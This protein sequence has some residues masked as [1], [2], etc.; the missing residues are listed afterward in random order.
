M[1]KQPNILWICT[2]QQRFDTI[3]ALG[4]SHIHT[5]NLD[6]LVEEGVSFLHAYV[7][8]PVCSP[9]RASFLTGRYPRTT[10]MRQNGTQIPADEVLISRILAD[11]GYRCGLAGKLHL[12]P[13]DGQM[14]ERIDDGYHDF[15]WSHGPWSKWEE[16][17]YIEWVD[18][19][20]KPWEDIYPFPPEIANKLGSHVLSPGGKQAWSGMPAL[21]HQ[22]YWCAEKAIEFINENRD[23]PWMF[24]VNPFDPHHPFDPPKE[25]LDRYSPDS[26]PSPRY[27]EGELLNKPIFQQ[28]DH[29]GAM[30]G[31]GISFKDTSD[32]VHREITAAYYAMIENVDDNIGRLLQ[33]LDESGQ[34]ENTLVIFMS[35]H[36]EMLGDHGIYLKGPFLYDVAVRVPLILSCPGSIKSGLRSEALV[37]LVDL[38]PTLLN[39]ADIPIPERMQGRSF[40]DICTGDAD[41][42]CHKEY[43]YAEYYNALTNHRDPTP[44]LTMV[45]DKKFKIVVYSGMELGELYDMENDPGEVTNLWNKPEYREIRFQYLQKCLDASVFTIDPMPKRVGEF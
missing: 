41:P 21:L 20:G 25:Y 22:S 19:K 30:G 40:L 15:H 4:N 24:S 11:N 39:F 16:N 27:T 7:Q 33:A 29:L 32:R 18:S 38:A 10:R 3:H 26:V 28:A 34:R 2:D 8:S 31:R 5:P 35:D 45:R 13:C 14:E 12:G 36:G 1:K 42:G 44:Y 6:R 23:T 37:E 43:V 17:A 9:S